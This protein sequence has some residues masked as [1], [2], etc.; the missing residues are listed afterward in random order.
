M[1]S[2]CG[3]EQ[4]KR[5][6]CHKCKV[7]SIVLTLWISFV[8]QENPATVRSRGGSVCRECFLIVTVHTFKKVFRNST[9]VTRGNSV[10]VGFS[11]GHS[12]R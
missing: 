12:S 11:G 8:R 7:F 4:K 1:A 6:K 3:A 9:E 5:R 2:F 10:L